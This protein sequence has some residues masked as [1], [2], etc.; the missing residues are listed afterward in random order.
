MDPAGG[1]KTQ[2]TRARYL[3][4]HIHCSLGVILCVVNLAITLLLLLVYVDDI[5]LTGDSQEQIF[6]TLARWITFLSWKSSVSS[7]NLSI[8]WSSSINRYLFSVLALT[9]F[10]GILRSN[11]LS[12]KAVPNPYTDATADLI[13]V[14]SF[15]FMASW[16]TSTLF[17]KWFSQ[18]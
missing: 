14:Q 12:V 11:R 8:F 16:L 9:L 7:I 6:N 10:P 5:L 15:P 3:M 13:W 17:A 4:L 1:I 18:K 2:H